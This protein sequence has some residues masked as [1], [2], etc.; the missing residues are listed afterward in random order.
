[1]R[2]QS[3]REFLFEKKDHLIRKLKNLSS[4]EKEELIQFFNGRIDLES[5]IDWNNKDLTFDDFKPIMGASKTGKAKSFKLN[6]INALKKGTDYQE[7][8]YKDGGVKMYIPLNY[9]VSKLLAS[10]KIG[11]CEGK[12]CIAYQKSSSHWNEYTKAQ[13]PVYLFTPSTKYAIMVDSND[14]IDS[15][16]DAED[17][18]I[19]ANEMDV[20][21]HR[22]IVSF[23]NSSDVYTNY[24]D[25][26]EQESHWIDAGIKNGSIKV[27]S[28]AKYDVKSDLEWYNGTWKSGTWQGGEWQD[29]TWVDGEWEKGVWENGIWQDGTWINGTWFNGTWEDGTWKYGIWYDGTWNGG[30]WKNGIWAKGTWLGGTWNDGT[31]KGGYDK[32][33]NYHQRDDS[34]DKW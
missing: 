31:W 4:D 32:D 34:P 16:W 33:G 26:V 25:S 3:F 19:D 22:S 18:K 28:D 7:L 20:H 27:G 15:I 14:K 29:G 2:T 21:D 5:K 24:S 13:V 23:I 30:T 8:K 12:W 9:E 11:A 10:N 6:G 1:M 17:K